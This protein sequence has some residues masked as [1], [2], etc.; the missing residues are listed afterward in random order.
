VTSSRRN[1]LVTTVFGAA[2][3]A[4]L[5]FGARTLFKYETTP[6][7]AG[8][9]TPNWP[10]VSVVPHQTD[11]PTLLML[12]HP[13]CPCTRA[14][15]GELAQVMAHAVGKVNAFVLF[16]KPRGAGTDWDDTDL[17]RSAAAIPGV[18]VLTDEN[19]T[20][21]ARFGAETSGHTLVFD[22]EGTL[23]FSGGIT[24]SRGHAG[25]N[26]GESAV[27]AALSRE[28]VT[29]SRTPVFGCALQ[30]RTSATEP[31]LCSK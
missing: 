29:Y 6:G 27:L 31:F 25:G 13:H 16:V 19:G 20:E 7:A 2:W 4:V 22:R 15:V 12:A 14:S 11:K 24:A 23:V 21:A 18:T 28:T 26:P 9:V 10:T 1:I 5:G 30:K 3:V 17:R 8:L